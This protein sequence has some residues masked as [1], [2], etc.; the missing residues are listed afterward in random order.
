MIKKNSFSK[1]SFIEKFQA[2][3]NGSLVIMVPQWQ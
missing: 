3:I 2:E 1:N